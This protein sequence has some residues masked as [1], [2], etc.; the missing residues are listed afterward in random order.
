MFL[1]LVSLDLVLRNMSS[2]SVNSIARNQ[3]P[4]PCSAFAVT[5]AV[6]LGTVARRDGQGPQ[7]FRS[8]FV[9]EKKVT[10]FVGEL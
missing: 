10:C 8:W 7:G 1:I 6:P 9:V 2:R 5:F 3:A 4:W